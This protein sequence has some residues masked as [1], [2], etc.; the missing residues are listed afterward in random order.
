MAIAVVLTPVQSANMTVMKI[1][2]GRQNFT[3]SEEK[4][5]ASGTD[6]K[7]EAAA[8]QLP[9][10]SNH[11]RL[12][13][14][15][16]SVGALIDALMGGRPLKMHVPEKCIKS[17]KGKF[18]IAAEAAEPVST[19]KPSKLALMRVK[20]EEAERVAKADAERA[21]R[22]MH[23]RWSVPCVVFICEVLR[24]NI[25]LD[26]SP[27]EGEADSGESPFTQS[28]SH[29]HESISGSRSAQ[30]LRKAEFSQHRHRELGCGNVDSP[31]QSKYQTRIILA[32]PWVHPH[33]PLATKDC[34][35][36]AQD[37]AKNHAAR[38]WIFEV[39]IGT[40]GCL[41][42]LDDRSVHVTAFP[43]AVPQRF[44]TVS[45]YKSIR[46]YELEN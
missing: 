15:A 11:H 45:L 25:V 17:P 13:C 9:T 3:S 8:P 20:R 40:N 37:A 22:P 27:G 6:R 46:V 28:E 42:H 4:S 14:R 38:Q 16:N 21:E 33:F 5:S 18:T 19:K 34:S 30:L 43:H 23:R 36:Y 39:F 26:R 12:Y 41:R 1:K 32:Q 44:K 24:D 7:A 31:R 2:V 29:K 35:K 10:C